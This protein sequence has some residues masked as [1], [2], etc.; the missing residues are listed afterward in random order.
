MRYATMLMVVACLAAG[1][2]AQDAAGPGGLEV[3]GPVDLRP[4]FVEGRSATYEVWTLRDTVNTFEGRGEQTEAGTTMEVTGQMTWTVERVRSDGSA[5]CVMV[6]DWLAVDITG[7]GGEVQSADSRRKIGDLPPLDVVLGALAG[8]PLA[9][10]VSARGV[11][12][13]IDGVAALRQ[14]VGEQGQLP[15]EL[16]FIEAATELAVLAAAPEAVEVGDDWDAAFTWTHDM[17]F[18]HHDTE[19]ELVSIEPVEGLPLATI[20]AT[21]EPRLE[22]DQDQMPGPDGPKIDVKLLEGEKVEQVLWDLS[23]HEAVGRN[24]VMDTVVRVTVSFQGSRF[25][26]TITERIQSQALRVSEE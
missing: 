11:V 17:G 9:C 25:I 16:D 22:L 20:T 8:E 26:R 18:L 5:T 13:S 14:A 4:R 12:E 6:Y 21:S 19:F 24:A 1:V 2:G 7:P 10:E 23:R 3:E 15:E